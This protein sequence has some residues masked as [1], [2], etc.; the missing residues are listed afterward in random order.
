MPTIAGKM[1]FLRAC[2]VS[3]LLLLVSACVRAADFS[4]ELARVQSGECQKARTEWWGYNPQDSTEN[5]QAA[6]VR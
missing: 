1:K 5:L 6:R 3:L 2:T 4:E